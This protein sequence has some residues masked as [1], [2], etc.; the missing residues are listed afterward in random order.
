MDSS[1]YAAMYEAEDSHWWYVGMRRIA[2][3]VLGAQLQPGK[4]LVILDAGC[5]TGGNLLFLES[6]GT[7]VGLDVSATALG[8]CQRRGLDRLVHGSVMSLP[9]PDGVFD[10]VTSLDVLY[11]RAVLDDAQA[12]REAR[13][14]LTPGGWLL[15][16]VPA[17][18]WLRGR[19]DV[20]VHTRHRYTAAE[21]A[22]KV[23]D[24]GLTVLRLSYANCLLFPIALAKRLAERI[25]PP[26]AGSD[27]GPPPA[28]NRQLAAILALEALWLRR[29]ALPWGLSVICLARKD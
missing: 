27:V 28:G 5:G 15:V 8:F 17:Y 4:P 2:A 7:P 24:A 20:A 14:V 22:N 13:R 19:H 23:C 11:H 9:F 6:Y 1:E 12:L 18:D 3:S 29:W 16:R 25:M 21:L 26:G 10:L